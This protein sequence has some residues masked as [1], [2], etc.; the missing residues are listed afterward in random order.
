[1]NIDWI[2]ETART[3]EYEYEGIDNPIE[4]LTA[5]FE[6]EFNVS[7]GE[8]IGGLIVYSDNIVYDYENFCGWVRVE[9]EDDGQ[10]TEME[11][12]LDFDPDC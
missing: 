3:V 11:E 12:W 2:N 6:A 8:D 5:R 10:P 9:D 4:T 7:E 1:M